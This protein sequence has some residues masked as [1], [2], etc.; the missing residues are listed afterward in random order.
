V[1]SRTQARWRHLADQIERE[2][3]SGLRPPGSQ[4]PSLTAQKSAG[5]SQTTALRAYQELINKGLAV[6]VHGAGTF[7]ADP[8]PDVA[9]QVTLEQLA[10]RVKVLEE[11]MS[12][13]PLE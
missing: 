7:V 3:R 13:L 6:S 12:R 5:Y 9:P 8:L 4:L 1:V 11:R 2:I 10:E